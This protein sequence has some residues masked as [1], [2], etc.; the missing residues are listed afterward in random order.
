MENITKCLKQNK[1]N[2]S[3]SSIKTYGS[4]L[5]SFYYKNHEKDSE[6]DCDWFNK[7]DE[8]VLLLKDKPASTRKTTYAALIAISSEN[9]KYKKALMEDGKKYQ[10]FIDKQEKTETQEENWKNYDEIKAIFADMSKRVKPILNSKVPL[11]AKSYS[12]LLDFIIVCITSGIFI[13]PRRSLDWIELKIKSPDKAADNY[14]E[15]NDFVFNKYKTAKFYG[16][17]K[18]E[19]PKELKLILTKFIKLNPHEYLLTEFNGTRVSN[20]RLTQKLNNIFEGKISTSML[21][22]IYLTDKLKDVP[23]LNDLKE[24]AS[25]MGHSVT[26][27]LQYVKK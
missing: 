2:I 26:E 24:M 20:V 19:M 13:S 10:A 7:Q 27:A 15:K 16:S 14:I 22:H 25:N 4:L 5:K 23:A 6:L 18:V 12:M 8:I 21:R 11:D 3:E 9:D 17:Q 1:P